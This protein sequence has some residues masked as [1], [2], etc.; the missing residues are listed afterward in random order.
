MNEIK[1]GDL[2]YAQL[3]INV[4]CEQS[5]KRPVVIIQND[6]GNE[7]S[8]TTIVAMITSQFK[9]YIPTHVQITNKSLPFNSIVMTEQVKTIDK[10]RLCKYIGCLTKDEINK[11]DLALKVSMGLYR[12]DN[13]NEIQ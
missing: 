2:Y 7:Y 11:I 9:K 3:P 5:G 1:R 10:S 6:V 13:E 8:P 12:K 4:G